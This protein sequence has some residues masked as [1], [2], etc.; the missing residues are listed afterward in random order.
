MISKTIIYHFFL[1]QFITNISKFLFLSI[2]SDVG[3]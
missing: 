2:I 3:A 1:K